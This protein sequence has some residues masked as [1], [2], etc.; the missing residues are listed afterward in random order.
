MRPFMLKGKSVLLVTNFSS[1]IWQFRRP[2]VAALQAE[3]AD[4]YVAAC[5][6]NYTEDVES[7][8]VTW[9]P[10]PGTM[11]TFNPVRE[12]ANLFHLTRIYLRIRPDIVH[13]YSIKPNMY[14]PFLARWVGAQ[15]VM[16]MVTGLGTVFIGGGRAKQVL[17]R[18][19]EAIYKR[20]FRRVNRVYFTNSDDERKFLAAKLVTAEQVR[21]IPGAGVDLTRF[22]PMSPER[23]KRLRCELGIDDEQRV[24]LFVGRFIAEKGVREVVEAFATTT[25]PAFL[26]LMIGPEY[27]HN[28]GA[29]NPTELIARDRRIR[30]LGEV[31]DMPP[32]YG[33]A[34]VVVL[35]S[36]REGMPTVLMEAAAMGLPAVATDVPGCREAVV[37]EKTGL[38]VPARDVAGL[39]EALNQL[40]EDDALRA[41]FGACA[42]ERSE[43]FDQQAIVASIIDDYHEALAGVE[44]PVDPVA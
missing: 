10:I 21:R 34:D 11:N 39:A 5:R 17:A 18:A 2:L 27:P 33:I 9:M 31:R 19:V 42:C 15:V 38:L 35:P 8:G 13:H 43:N 20:A 29:V 4:V 32:Y 6:D 23:S 26:L 30:Y 22:H 16:S 7:L 40:L 1:D 25:N 37:H 41:R 3:G 28:P 44:T 14:G 36:Y 24:V 12:V